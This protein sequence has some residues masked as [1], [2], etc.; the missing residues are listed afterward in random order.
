MYIATILTA[1][2]LLLVTVLAIYIAGYFLLAD[3][4]GLYRGRW[5]F[6]LYEP[7]F[8]VQRWATGEPVN[9]GYVEPNG[10]HRNL[11]LP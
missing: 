2:P 1:A 4:K 10:L 5:Q 3:S 6:V 11:R 7:A 8:R 9:T